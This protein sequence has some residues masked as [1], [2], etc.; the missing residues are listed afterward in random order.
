MAKISGSAGGFSQEIGGYFEIVDKARIF[1]RL[2]VPIRYLRRWDGCTVTSAFNPWPSSMGLPRFLLIGVIL[3]NT[4]ELP[5]SVLRI[6][7]SQTWVPENDANFGFGTHLEPMNWANEKGCPKFSRSHW[8][9]LENLKSTVPLDSPIDSCGDVSF[10]LE[11]I[12][13]K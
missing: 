10:I 4:L 11:H 7:S 13:N 6:R 2:V 1:A 5:S 9:C 12:M 3:P 8:D